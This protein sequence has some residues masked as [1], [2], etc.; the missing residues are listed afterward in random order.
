[1]TE[2]HMFISDLD[3]T[4]FRSDRRFSNKDLD[5]LTLL[6]EMGITRVLATGRSV[7]SLQ[8]S[9]PEP[10][11]FDYLIFSTGLGIANY[12]DSNQQII[13]SH[14]LTAEQTTE[15]A[16][17]FKELSLDFMIHAP[18]P[19]N[20]AFTFDYP[21]GNNPDFM[22]RIGFYENHCREMEN[23]GGKP[24][25]SSQFITMIPGS[26]ALDLYHHI[27]ESL[28]QF[29]VI[30]TTSPF[31]GKTMW[32]EVFPKNVSKGT[33]VLWLADQLGIDR[34]NIAA[35][36]NDYNDEDLLEIAEKAYVVKNAPEDL[37]RKF[38]VVSSNDNEGVSDAVMAAF[39]V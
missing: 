4:L 13:K 32:I 5:R 9:V 22:T 29:S 31:D 27:K 39:G 25:P 38:N 6:G 2:K 1:M 30:K 37:K 14:G 17:L 24:G 12:P 11:P 7:F 28:G 19:H 16:E 35:V 23:S 3:G 20:H 10:L 26:S 34:K 15:V 33:A 21:S 18:L 8:R 36:G